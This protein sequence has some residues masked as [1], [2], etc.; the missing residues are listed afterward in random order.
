MRD[1]WYHHYYTA[2]QEGMSEDQA[3]EHADYNAEHYDE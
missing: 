2:L 1:V 3:I